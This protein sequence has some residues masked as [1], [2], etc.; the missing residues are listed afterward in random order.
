MEQCAANVGIL[1][2]LLEYATNQLKVIGKYEQL[3]DANE[4]VILHLLIPFKE[5]CE[6]FTRCNSLITTTIKEN[7]E[8]EPDYVPEIIALKKANA[9]SVYGRLKLSN[10]AKLA[11]VLDPSVR[12]TLKKKISWQRPCRGLLQVASLRLVLQLYHL[13]MQVHY[14]CLL[15]VLEPVSEKQRMLNNMKSASTDTKA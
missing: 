1:E 6:Q 10:T 4:T 3:L 15:L 9:S 2:D 5:R 8:F 11:C 12:D 7:C 13:L 14:C